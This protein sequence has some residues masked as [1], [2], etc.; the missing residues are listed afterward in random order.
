MAIKDEINEITGAVEDA[1][2]YPILVKEVDG[3]GNGSRSGGDTPN[4]P[5]GGSLTRA[6]QG[7]MRD[8]LGWRYRADD[9]KGFMA[10][11]NKA[12]DLKE[13]EGRTE[14]TWKSRPFMAQADLGEVTGAQASICKRA[15]VAVEQV[16]LL[17]DGLTPLRLDVDKDQVESIRAIVRSA[18][19]ELVN[20]LA[21]VSGPRIQ[22]VDLYF[23]QL[24]GSSNPRDIPE[25]FSHPEKVK[26]NLGKLGRRF[27]LDRN[28]VLMVEE[29]Q[30][31]TNFLIL[32]D[33]TTSLLQ[34]WDAQKAFLVRNG[35]GK[36]FLG[37]QLVRLSEEL[38]VIVESVHEIYAAMDSV[39]FGMEERQVAVLDFEE[40]MGFHVKPITV[41]ELLSWIEQFSSI[42]ASQL[43]EDSGK[44]GV[45]M[46]SDTL[47]Q[48]RDM[49][50]AI[51]SQ[52]Q[53]LKMP[54]AFHTRRV[55]E[56][57]DSL[58]THVTAAQRI[59]ASLDPVKTPALN[60]HDEGE[61]RYQISLIQPEWT[62][63]KRD[64]EF[65]IVGRNLAKA[66]IKELRL[67]SDKDEARGQVGSDP[68][69]NLHAKLDLS[70]T[71]PGMYEVSI[72]DKNGTH[73]PGFFVDVR[74][75]KHPPEPLHIIGPHDQVKILG[76]SVSFSVVVDKAS[77]I[78]YQWY[79]DGRLLTNETKA[80][81]K[82][83][84]VKSEDEGTYQVRI[85]NHDTHLFLITR[86]TVNQ[87]ST[88]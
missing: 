23:Q 88:R 47:E 75:A 30:N 37:T 50:N 7:A 70:K 1:V 69:G 55:I 35:G 60:L 27:G 61:S 4:L 25:V 24:L 10:A 51:V 41:A 76:E 28:G 84:K 81:L 38:A 79:K 43:I 65:R 44:D 49:L 46:V 21:V 66:G 56:S 74:E 36:K 62:D 53:K 5:G 22:R 57:L 9:P 59:A 11:L 68:H 33:Y 54:R 58:A 14:W 80:T 67:F 64:T 71:P 19:N 13:M 17:L 12:V 63:A 18:W 32:V 40:T 77:N 78:E 45:L 8:L 86:L 3:Y 20:E 48:L 26:G 72:M 82:I 6:A 31:F 2:T 34:T 85:R 42:E 87:L 15:Q 83:D 16:F 52:P 73:L 29:E 39:F